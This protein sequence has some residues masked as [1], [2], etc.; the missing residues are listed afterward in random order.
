MIELS[1]SLT[2]ALQFSTDRMLSF[3]ET[4]GPI[5]HKAVQTNCELRYYNVSA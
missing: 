3:L 4:V 5:T 1:M 2:G